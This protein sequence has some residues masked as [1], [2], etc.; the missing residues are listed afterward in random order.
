M[1]VREARVLI[2]DDNKVNRLLLAR[3]VELLGHR[4]AM[5]E[6]GRVGLETLRKDAYDLLL[7]DIDMPEMDGFAVLEEMQADSRL[8]DV[9]VIVTSAREGLDNVVR[10]ISLGADDYLP[11]P[12]NTVL[13]K[14][15]I[16]ACLEKKRLRDE[17]RAL[18]QR[19]ATPEVAEE[20][21]RT[22]FALG[23]QRVHA[24]VM[25]CDIRGFTTMVETQPPE[26]T[27]DVLNTYY[28]LMFDAI[29]SHGGVVNQMI[30][31]GLMILFGAPSPLK[32]CAASAVAASLEMHEMMAQF[33]VERAQEGKGPVRIGIGIAT[34]NVVAGY[35]GTQRRATYT[36][37]GD[38][39]NLA[40]R[41]EAH[42]KDVG[43]GILIDQATQLDIPQSHPTEP[44]GAIKFR[45]K[46]GT[47]NV[48]AVTVPSEK[49]AASKVGSPSKKRER[50]HPRS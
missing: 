34:G 18:V 16:G 37:I 50:P 33:N 28:T 5:A 30:G 47:E 17:Q 8:R 20:L 13:L 22:G 44:L 11:K 48:F 26:E 2:T 1:A 27:I 46:S 23:G 35:T 31:D 21:Q 7:L 19:F 12:V 32:N 25:F 15:R 49:V 4:I 40:A 29:G 6:N 3:M 36:C 39:V 24:T 43:R 14:A 41:L 38:T 42:T 45:G 10:C 9:A